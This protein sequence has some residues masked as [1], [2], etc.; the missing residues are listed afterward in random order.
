LKNFSEIDRALLFL[1]LLLLFFVVAIP[2]ATSTFAAYL[3]QG[4]HGATLAAVGL[5]GRVCGHVA[6]LWR[7]VLMG[8]PTRAHEGRLHPQ[9]RPP[10]TDQVRH[11][12]PSGSPSSVRPPRS[13]SVPW[14]AS[15]TYSSRPRP[16]RRRPQL[17]V[18]HRTTEPMTANP[19]QTRSKYMID[20]GAISP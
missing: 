14:S 7:A 5:P 20:A 1:N 12:R 3:P 13:S 19:G 2:F 16:A 15:A 8:P 4:G 11:R 9:E 17:R 18:P 10:G 6:E